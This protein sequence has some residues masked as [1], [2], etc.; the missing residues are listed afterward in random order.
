LRLAAAAVA[1]IVTALAVGGCSGTDVAWDSEKGP[2]MPV[3]VVVVERIETDKPEWQRLARRIRSELI[4]ELGDNPSF[5]A[6][7]KAAP[8]LARPGLIRV[9]GRIEALDPG[10]DI[11]AVAT[12][13]IGWGG[14]EL[15]ARFRILGDG[16]R[17]YAD[18]TQ[19]VTASRPLAETTVIGTMFTAHFDPLYADDLADA[20]AAEAADAIAA[21]AAVKEPN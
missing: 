18:F 4:A 12:G 15:R 6:V 5:D 10:V 8:G 17:L 13:D 9:D 20:L 21:W 14:A 1:V 2:P 7:G 3:R 16:D 11:L 19:T